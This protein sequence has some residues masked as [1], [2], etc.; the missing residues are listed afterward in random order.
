MKHEHSPVPISP[1]GFPNPQ[2]VPGHQSHHPYGY[3]AD[4]FED[5]KSFDPLKLLWLVVHYRWLIAT[6]LFVGVVLGTVFTWMQTP[7]YRSTAKIEIMTVGAR[8]FQDIEVV[9]QSSNF[10]AYETAREKILS[11]DLARRVVYELNL[12]EKPEFLAPTASFSLLNLVKKALGSSGSNSIM[13]LS[14]EARETTAINIV[15]KNLSAQLLRNTSL[16]AV[17]FSHAVPKYASDV[18]NQV[19]RSFIDQTVDTKSETSELARQFIQEQVIETKKK[20]EAS[21]KA[22]VKYAKDAS[23]T[24]TGDDAS[25][26]TE[27]ISQINESLSK[28]IDD[29]L[30]AERYLE[31]VKQGGAQ[32][33]PQVFDSNS[34]QDSKRQITELK[35]TYQQKLATLKPG[36]PEMRRLSAQIKETERQMQLEIAAIAKSVEIMHAQAVRKEEALRNELAKLEASHAEF[37]EK[38]IN[39]TILKREVDSNRSQFDT[40]ISKLNEIGIGSDLKT[41]NA[42]IVDLA[43]EPGAPYSP[44]LKVN[45]IASFALFGAI[46][47]G[48]IYLL[49]L[50][51]NTFAIPDQIESELKI[52]VLG[53]IPDTPDSRIMEELADDK[54]ALSEAYRTLRTSLQFAGT[55]GT[56][57]TLLVTSSEPSEGKST[58]SYKLA[59]DFAALGR[60]V[61]LVDADMRKP[62]LHRLFDTD[63]G[64]GLSNLLSNV[65]RQGNVASIFRSTNNPKVTFLSAGTIPP[66]PSDLLV[67]QKMGLTLHYCAKKYDMVIIDA[68]P[69][70]GLSD[71]PILS[72]IVDG[73]LLVVAAKQVPRKAAKSAMKRLKAANANVVGAV[74]NKFSVSKVDYNYAYRYMSYNYYTYEGESEKLEHHGE[75]KQ[76][77]GAT[78]AVAA[79]SG[80]VDRFANRFG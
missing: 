47:A 61:L 45:V 69:V 17:S 16:I 57:R 79:V 19:A 72:R 67:S 28:A 13:E 12:S 49:E 80:W 2:G 18:T 56:V 41:A 70:M 6:L 29:R 46:A 9:S 68:P 58:T 20:L 50:L 63:N 39:Y 23:I 52:P 34:I 51:N 35:A 75:A 74:M 24:V 54:S 32:S 38:N 8:V 27:N 33:L 11:R 66:N 10:R 7:L 60:S 36:Y 44:N 42:N 4:P 77:N 73:T 21:E 31:Q 55:E 1:L 76:S 15:Q 53:I 65:V 30:V 71:A 5:E 48:L 40:L 78:G 25:L 59:Q 14:P 37:Q 3:T 22:L 26:I 62:K 64:I 43:I